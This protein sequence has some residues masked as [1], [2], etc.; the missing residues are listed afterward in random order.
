MTAWFNKLT[1]V[2]NKA[3]WHYSNKDF[4]LPYE[5]ATGSVTL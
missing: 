1:D 3:E 2:L 5:F 4:T